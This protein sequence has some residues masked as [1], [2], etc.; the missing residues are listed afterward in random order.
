MTMRQHAFNNSMVERR[1]SLSMADIETKFKMFIENI[2]EGEEE[3]IDEDSK[4]RT[5]KGSERTFKET[6]RMIMDPNSTES[7]NFIKNKFLIN[8]AVVK[9]R[10]QKHLTNPN[11][12]PQTARKSSLLTKPSVAAN[13]TARAGFG[14]AEPETAGLIRSQ[15]GPKTPQPKSLGLA[16]IL[17]SNRGTPMLNVVKP[18][19]RTPKAADTSA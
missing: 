6:S 3:H 9:D 14:L 7:K 16:S 2:E 17:N 12:F 8:K 11:A 15:F 4:F 10:N 18:T 19:D 1:K 5:R 13:Q